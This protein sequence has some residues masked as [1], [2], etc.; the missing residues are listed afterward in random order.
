MQPTPRARTMRRQRWARAHIQVT[1]IEQRWPAPPGI[2]SGP[3]RAR[4]S[5]VIHRIIVAE[6]G[7][8]A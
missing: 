5:D 6:R 1:P 7:R 4:A 8:K 3:L 2:D